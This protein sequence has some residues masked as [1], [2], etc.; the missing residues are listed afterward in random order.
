MSE[1][2][3]IEALRKKRALELQRKHRFEF[4][5]LEVAQAIRRRPDYQKKGEIFTDDYS[6]ANIL[7][8]R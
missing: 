2:E 1:D 3:E 8:R 7:R 5:L 6:P 4:R